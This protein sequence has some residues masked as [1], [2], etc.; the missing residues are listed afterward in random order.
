MR[1]TY[2]LLF[3][4]FA[5]LFFSCQEKQELVEE[6]AG[7]LRLQIGANTALGTKAEEVYNPKQLTVKILNSAGKVEWETDDWSKEESQSIKLP[8][9]KYTIQASSAGFDGKSS[10]FDKPYYAGT[11]EDVLVEKNKETSVKLTCTLANVKVTVNFDDSFEVAFK[12][13]AVTIGGIANSAE[14]LNFKMGEMSKSAYYPVTNLYAK[15]AVTNKSGI[16]HSQTDTIKNVK[17]R[18]HYIFNYSVAASG[19]GS[20]SIDVDESTR[21]YTFHFAVDPTPKT[22]L[23]ASANAWSKFAYLNGKI[24]SATEELDPELMSFQYRLESSGEDGEWTKIAATAKE[25]S[26]EGKIEGLTPNT[27]YQYRLIYGDEQFV[28]PTYTFTTENT[29]SLYNGNFDNWAHGTG[30]YK[31]TWFA[32]FAQKQEGFN[33]VAGFNT[34]FWDSGNIGTSTG[35]AAILGAKNPTAPEESIVHTP[36]GKSAKLESIYVAIQFAAGNIYTGNY[37]ET[38]MNPMGARINWGQPFTSRP[39]ALHGWIQYTPGTVNRGKNENL[40]D[41]ATLHLDDTDQN[42]IYIALSDKGSQYEIMNG[43]K[44]FIDF[45]NDPN[46][47]AYGELPQEECVKTDGWKEVNIPLVYNAIDRKPTHIIIVF[48]ASKYGDYFVGSDKSVMYVDDF[49]LIYDGEPTIKN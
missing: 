24:V 25:D 44:K 46:I 29:I 40:P 10:A 3:L 16:S 21:T 6:N 7:Y 34:S 35:A 12:S 5:T 1:I 17:A 22:N 42:A 49:E 32:D 9:G 38:I 26:F 43:E 14:A 39:T 28:S 15:V 31:N 4:L 41:D 11:Q 13:A 37:Q 45:D 30:D 27:S 2:N 18:D 36:G 33:Y 8:T 23:S 47:I 19:S 20:I 48:S